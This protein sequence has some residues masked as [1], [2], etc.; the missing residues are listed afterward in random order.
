M[1]NYPKEVFTSIKQAKGITKTFSATAE[2][3]SDPEK[4]LC[5]AGWSRFELAMI[6]KG[7]TMVINTGNIPA[8]EIYAIYDIAQHVISESIIV[9][10]MQ[11]YATQPKEIETPLHNALRVSPKMGANKGKPYSTLCA[12]REF[13]EKQKSFLEANVAKSPANQAEIDAIKI[14]LSADSETLQKA[15]SDLSD[16]SVPISSTVCSIYDSGMKPLQSK[17]DE[18][19][20]SKCYRIL[21][22]YDV[23]MKYPFCISIENVWAPVI[24][25][26]SGSLNIQM[27][28]A[29]KRTLTKTNL[30]RIEGL[31]FLNY[32]KEK[33]SQFEQSSFAE[34]FGKAQKMYKEN[35]AASKVEKTS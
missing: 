31:S 25:T 9:A 17:R 8:R 14:I 20:R 33:V 28:Q 18:E 12:N 23:S 7:T 3:G 32:L 4:P 10:A 2:L 21:I 16:N 1:S 35:I 30:S 19:N 22:D 13:M 27:S 15:I 24:K 34:Q 6:E 29:T 5:H 11:H 26:D